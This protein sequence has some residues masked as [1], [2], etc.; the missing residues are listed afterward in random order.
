MLPNLDENPRKSGLCVGGRSLL[1]MP[2]EKSF[3]GGIENFK[4]FPGG[5]TDLDDT[6]YWKW[7]FH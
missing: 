1:K 6:V 3:W 5:G 7:H 2:G 4:I